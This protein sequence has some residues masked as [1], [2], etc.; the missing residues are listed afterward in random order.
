MTSPGSGGA[1]DHESIAS[2][3]NW[4]RAPALG[5]RG[6]GE[7]YGERQNGPNG[8]QSTA[9]IMTGRRRTAAFGGSALRG[10]RG[11]K[12]GSGKT[13]SSPGSPCHGRRG[14]GRTDGGAA[15]R[16]RRRPEAEENGRRRRIPASRLDSLAREV[17][18]DA[19]ELMAMSV[20]FGVAGVN[21][22]HDGGG[23]GP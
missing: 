1:V 6:G 22:L 13:S 3:R 8:H 19:M 20:G 4:M 11:R 10:P 9:G 18:D 15:G 2:V 23:G 7:E 17:E 16:E 14:E 5:A 12:R 21:G